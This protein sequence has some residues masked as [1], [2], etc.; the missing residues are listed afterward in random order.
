MSIRQTDMPQGW[1]WYVCDDL[2]P[3]EREELRIGH[4]HFVCCLEQRRFQ[5]MQSPRIRSRDEG[6]EA[7]YG[8]LPY[9]D[10]PN[11]QDEEDSQ[12]FFYANERYLFTSRLCYSRMDGLEESELLRRMQ[13]CGTAVEGMFVLVNEL[14]LVCLN[15]LD[16]IAEKLASLERR[17]REY[18]NSQLLDQLI[19][20]Q[21]DLV[22]W[23]HRI[24]PLGELLLA[25]K[26]AFTP[27]RLEQGGQ[28]RAASLRVE[29]LMMRLDR[30]HDE[31]R[32]LLA[33]DENIASYRGND[34]MKTLTVFT[35]VCT[36]ATVFA[37]IWGMNFEHLPGIESVMGFVVM[38][39][40]MLL[41]TLLVYGWLRWKGW[42]GDLIR[43]KKKSSNIV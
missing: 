6:M 22:R 42:T 4:P 39:A 12:A 36:P 27:E 21:Y 25:A 13:S 29:R 1:T 19:E 34:I 32:A 24:V 28:F 35:V 16:S 38:I 40:V 31:V 2:T 30:F 14:A 15:G 33:M 8:P 43:G 41:L 9:G 26:E 37:G 11:E 5:R 3:M 23:H 17:M 7:L 10:F 18:N 20:R